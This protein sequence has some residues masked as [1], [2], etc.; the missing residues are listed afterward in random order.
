MIQIDNVSLSYT[1]HE[2]E[3]EEVGFAVGAGE[4]VSLVGPSG[5]GKSTL[6]RLIA[7]V[8]TPQ[9]GEVRLGGS[10]Y[11]G[12]RRGSASSRRTACSCPG[13]QSSAMWP[14]LS[15]WR[16]CGRAGKERARTLLELVGMG[17]AAAKYPGA[18][19]GGGTPARGHRPRSGRR[20]HGTPAR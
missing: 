6:L 14:F 17:A 5:C 15:N 9:T 13:A 8:L 18:L 11:K 12:G 4:F 1:G 10:P 3:L 20:S 2:R 19:S 16:V 7:G